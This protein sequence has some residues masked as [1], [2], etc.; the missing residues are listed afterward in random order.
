MK[1]LTSHVTRLEKTPDAA[2]TELWENKPVGGSPHR[3]EALQGLFT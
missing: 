1:S 2:E 3:S